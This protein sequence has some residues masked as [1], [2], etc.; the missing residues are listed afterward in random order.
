MII[1]IIITITI[2][3]IIHWACFETYKKVSYL[4][5]VTDGISLYSKQEWEKSNHYHQQQHKSN[6]LIIDIFFF[7]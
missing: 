7:K 5:L 6:Q 4:S 3:I 2:I 1:I